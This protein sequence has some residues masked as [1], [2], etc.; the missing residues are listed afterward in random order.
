MFVSQHADTLAISGCLTQEIESNQRRKRALASRQN[1]GT[2][3]DDDG[4][5]TTAGGR[6]HI[7]VNGLAPPMM[8]EILDP[9]VVHVS[10][11]RICVGLVRTTYSLSYFENGL[12][13]LLIAF[14]SIPLP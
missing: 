3:R 5:A 2:V 7:T 6:R 4:S 12:I 11:S 8:I 1:A 13:N 14:W 9:S 10:V